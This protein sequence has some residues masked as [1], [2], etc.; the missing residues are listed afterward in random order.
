MQVIKLSPFTDDMI[1]HIENPKK[2]HLEVIR[3]NKH[4][5]QLCSLQYSHTNSDV[6]LYTS[7]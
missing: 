7:N 4:T 2:I 1:I 5:Q 6:F 3:A